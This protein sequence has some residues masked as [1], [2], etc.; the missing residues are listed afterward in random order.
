ML[1]AAA[2][3]GVGLTQFRGHLDLDVPS[4]RRCTHGDSKEGAPRLHRGVSRGSGADDE[5]RRR[6]G[7]TLAQIGRELDLEP[8]VLRKWARQLGAWTPDLH[9]PR[10]EPSTDAELQR[11]VRRL[12]REVEVLRQER[13]FLKKATAYF[14]KESP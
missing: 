2:D 8:D 5:R 13:E 10:P 11:E 7:I 12:R 3:C 9:V 1:N 6:E 4:E 14:A